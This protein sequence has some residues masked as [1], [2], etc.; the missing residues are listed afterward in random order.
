MS[1]GLF[2]P[3]DKELKRE[4]KVGR[5]ARDVSAHTNAQ[6]VCFFSFSS[7]SVWSRE[8]ICTTL[9]HKKGNDKDL[10]DLTV[11]YANLYSF[12]IYVFIF[13]GEII[14]FRKLHLFTYILYIFLDDNMHYSENVANSKRPN[15]NQI[16][17]YINI[18]HVWN[19]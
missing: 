6:G 2:P 9:V 5:R 16:F 1:W 4:R 19:I 17:L 8:Y 15:F 3:R 13:Y 7:I 14:N 11:S 10:N 12:L 18:L